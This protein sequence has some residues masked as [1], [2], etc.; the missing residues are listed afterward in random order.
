MRTIKKIIDEMDFLYKNT[1]Y[2]AVRLIISKAIYLEGKY[3]IKILSS[4]NVILAI[5][6][7]GK[8]FLDK[9]IAK[10]NLRG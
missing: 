7:Y 6:I 10:K 2:S 9:E 4:K 8:T 3:S 1:I 5:K